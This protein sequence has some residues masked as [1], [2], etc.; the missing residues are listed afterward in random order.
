MTA[1][2]MQGGKDLFGWG[3]ERHLLADIYDAVNVNT[4]VSGQWKKGSEPKFSPWPRPS[5]KPKPAPGEK[6]KTTVRDL[7]ELFSRKR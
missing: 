6:K 1:A 7:Y 3:T 5:T 2:L 4:R